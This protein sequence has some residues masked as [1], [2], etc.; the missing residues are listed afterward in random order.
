MVLAEYLN[1]QDG[2]TI[3]T[4]TY[5]LPNDIHDRLDSLRTIDVEDSS[6]QR[7]NK[8][9]KYV[10]FAVD[11]LDTLTHDE[12]VNV[13]RKKWPLDD[14]NWLFKLLGYSEHLCQLGLSG[15]KTCNDT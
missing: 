1:N 8:T 6:D 14:V 13:L 3:M 7:Y 10:I 9:T 12:L 15:F 2:H 5:Q 4:D 11:K